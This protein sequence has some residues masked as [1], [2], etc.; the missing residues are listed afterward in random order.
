MFHPYRLV[1]TGSTRSPC[2]LV[3]YLYRR[4]GLRRLGGNLLQPHGDIR[5]ENFAN[6]A[7]VGGDGQRGRAG[8]GSP[9]KRF[10][11]V[12]IRLAQMADALSHFQHDAFHLGALAEPVRA[13]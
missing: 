8:E 9:A 13:L 11:P 3:F 5:T 1:E 2:G 7:T 4:R 10:D 12:W 6:L